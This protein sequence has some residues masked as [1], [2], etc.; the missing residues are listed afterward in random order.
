MAYTDP[1]R[2]YPG[3]TN[4]DTGTYTKDNKEFLSI[5]MGE[6][7][8]AFSE[9]NVMTGRTM[10]RTITSGKSADFPA[11]WKATARYHTPGSMILGS[12]QVKFG[13]RT[14]NIDDYLIADVFVYDLDEAKSHWDVRSI[15]SKEMGNALARTYD[16]NMLKVGCLAARAAGTNTGTTAGVDASW[17]GTQLSAGATA[18]TDGELL[19]SYFFKA[20]QTLDEKDVP[21]G[22]RFA[23]VKPAQYYLLAQT[24]RVINKDWGGAGTYSDGKIYN[25]AGIELVKT[26][27]LPSTNIASGTTGEQNTYYGDFTKTTALIMN[28]MAIGTVKLK[29]LNVMMTGHD[30]YVMYLGTLLVGAYAMGHG[31]LRPECAVEIL[32]Q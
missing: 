3:A 9:T 14:I 30:F 2:S 1:V 23:Y 27:N 15:Y 26:N 22:E 5:F 32:A 25:I 4:N 29:E 28:K 6:V 24:T 16:K 17:G 11:T 31:I 10:E 7:Y 21:E 19:A 13:K 8:T 12:N 20:A 18:G